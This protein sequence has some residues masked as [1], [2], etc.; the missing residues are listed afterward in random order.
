MESVREPSTSISGVNEIQEQET[1]EIALKSTLLVSDANIGD[2]TEEIE[3]Q[4]SVVIMPE[5][6]RG[7][8]NMVEKPGE[9]EEGKFLRSPSLINIGSE[10]DGLWS[11]VTHWG[12]GV[13][14][15]IWC[16][17]K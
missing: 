11:K 15:A 8:G 4:H 6:V 3:I 13:T 2:V 14:R 10:D 5:E 7:E 17:D 9:A 1:S 12:G 16:M